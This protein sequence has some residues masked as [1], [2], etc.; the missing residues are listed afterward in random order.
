MNFL[1]NQIKKQKEMIAYLF[2]GG[3]TTIINLLVYHCSYWFLGLNNVKSTVAAW[4]VS[5]LFAFITNKFFVFNYRTA[6]IKTISYESVKFFLS[7]LTTGIIEVILMYIFVDLLLANGSV[8]KLTTNVIVIILNYAA[9]KLFVFTNS[10]QNI[11][12][13]KD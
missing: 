7:R 3:L 10:R 13:S 2:F 4:L 1:I 8:M 11:N 9:S 12:S 5:V 6:S